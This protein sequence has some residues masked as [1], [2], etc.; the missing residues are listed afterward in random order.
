MKFTASQIAGIL[1]GEVQ[2]NPEIAVDKLSKIEEGE[3]ESKQEERNLAPFIGSSGRHSSVRDLV[4]LLGRISST[5]R[6]EPGVTYCTESQRILCMAECYDVFIGWNPCSKQRRTFAM[7]IL[8]PAWG[9]SPT[10]V[11]TYIED[12]QP[13][14]KISKD[15]LEV[16]RCTIH[17]PD[18]N[19]KF[20][21]NEAENKFVD[22]NY[23]L[24]L[25]EAAG[26]SI[27]LNESTLLVGGE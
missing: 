13:P 14:I 19:S 16:G 22:T 17:C 15:L 25:M 23:A 11:T 20:L 10:T 26:I 1:E 5:V 4:K 12:R 2:G 3:S 9:L 18:R 8:A 24:R 27:A 6:F 7:D 21:M